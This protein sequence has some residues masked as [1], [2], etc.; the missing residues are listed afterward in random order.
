MEDNTDHSLLGGAIF[1]DAGTGG[2][3]DA[4]LTATIEDLGVAVLY[5]DEELRKQG[6]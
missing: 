3:F 1:P 6:A 5:L 4:F 2:R